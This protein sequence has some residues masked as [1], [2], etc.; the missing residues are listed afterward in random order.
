MIKYYP[1]ITFLL[2]IGFVPFLRGKWKGLHVEEAT[3]QEILLTYLRCLLQ[4]S[5][6]NYMGELTLGAKILN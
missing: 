6:Q 2:T 1:G 3:I 5:L 4:I